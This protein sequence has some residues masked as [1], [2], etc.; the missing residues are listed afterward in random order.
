[1]SFVNSCRGAKITAE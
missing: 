1:L